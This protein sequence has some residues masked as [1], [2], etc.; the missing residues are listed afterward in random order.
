MYALKAVWSEATEVIGEAGV[1]PSPLIR[2]WGI[3]ANDEVIQ[4][5]TR[6]SKRF[7]GEKLSARSLRPTHAMKK[8]R[9]SLN[10]CRDDDLSFAKDF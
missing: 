3:Q 10:R 8:A 2:G 1:A 6:L 7:V 5:V 9:V 4:T